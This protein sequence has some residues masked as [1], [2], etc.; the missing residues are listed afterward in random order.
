MQRAWKRAPAPRH[1][2]TCVRPA[3]PHRLTDEE[4]FGFK[5]WRIDNGFANKSWTQNRTQNEAAGSANAGKFV[6]YAMAKSLIIRSRSALGAGGRWFKSNRPDQCSSTTYADQ[7]PSQN[8][9]V[10]CFVTQLPPNLL[11]LPSAPSAIQW[12]GQPWEFA[13]LALLRPSSWHPDGCVNSAGAS[14][15]KR[16]RQFP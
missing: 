6:F 16:V 5:C 4:F 10:T 9:F 15:L 1:S 14:P 2:M 11:N 13:S 8:L 12:S 3:L 7:N